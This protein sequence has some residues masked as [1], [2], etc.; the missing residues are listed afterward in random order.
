MSSAQPK[1]RTELGKALQYFRR[2][3]I[4]LA[5]FSLVINIVNLAPALYMLQVYDRVLNS[6]NKTTLL[7]LSLLVVGLYALSGLLQ[8]MRSSVLIRV[9]NRFDSMLGQRVF[10]AAFER[11]LRR[12]GGNPSQAL[13]DLNTVRQFMTGN[14]LFSFFDTPFTPIYIAV[15]FMVHPMLGLINVLGL[16]VLVSL[17][18]LTHVMTH[19]PLEEANKASLRANVFANNH[20]N[21]A[22]VIEA[23][24]MLSGL[25]QR[26]HDQH[27]RMLSLQSVA[28]DRNA[29]ISSLSR[30]I[31]IS[32]QSLILGAGALLVIDGQITPGMM[33]VCSILMG[34]AL[35][36]VEMLIGT[37]KQFVSARGAYERVDEMLDKAPARADSLSLPAPRGE[38]LLESVFASHP[39]GRAAI[40]KSI[41]FKIEAGDVVGIIGPSGAGK[42]TLA[43][44]LVGVWGAQSGT[45]RLDG[46]DIYR[47][48][49]DELGPHI[50]YLPQDI[51]LFEGTV[52]EN[53]ARFETPD[54]TKVV[55]AAKQADV[56]EMILNLPNGYET[57]LGLN[58][59]ALSGGQRQ[60]VALA[61]AIYGNPA[62]VVLDEPNSNLDQVGEAALVRTIATLKERGATVVVVTHRANI[63]KAMDKLLVMRDGTVMTYGERD[64]VLKALQAQRQQDAAANNRL[65]GAANPV[66]RVASDRTDNA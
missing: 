66:L 15:A 13:R 53:I 2:V 18:Y 55:A 30:F 27:R 44:L 5:A 46:A 6:Q 39:G 36:P 49:K 16:V 40:L 35:R 48:N 33:I 41:N 4:S 38:L 10:T 56:H 26:W 43:R 17:A 60:R 9:G 3:F 50:G 37:W 51:E 42:S 64:D 24:G 11:N 20:L 62:L 61:R 25:R 31:R 19:K 58:G 45:V 7:M 63:L 28:S 32:L 52:A 34:Q 65:K 21:N 12:E 57:Q 47:W 1:T 54:S 29:R 23:M 8:L 14:G 59:S 22:E